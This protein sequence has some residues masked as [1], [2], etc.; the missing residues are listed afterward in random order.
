MQANGYE[1]LPHNDQDAI[2]FHLVHHGPLAISVWVDQGWF[3]YHSGV[4]NGCNYKSNMDMNHA[5]TLVGYG[6][7]KDLGDYWV[8]RN[9]WG[10]DWGE[11][12]YMRLK[13]E[14]NP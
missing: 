1:K 8:I 11:N 6:T 7:D 9:H 3:S 4:Y 5:V 10:D 2:M 12:G 13:R 14:K